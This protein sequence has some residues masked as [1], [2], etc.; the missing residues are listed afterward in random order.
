MGRCTWLSLLYLGKQ[1]AGG[2]LLTEFKSMEYTEIRERTDLSL[3]PRSDN[4]YRTPLYLR[5]HFL[6]FAQ[7]KI[8][9]MWS[10]PGVRLAREMHLSVYKELE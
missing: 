10:P 3:I 5:I 7:T 8:V 4:T 6:S 9:D 2:L 1:I